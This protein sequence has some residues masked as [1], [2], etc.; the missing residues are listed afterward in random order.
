MTWTVGLGDADRDAHSRFGLPEGVAFAILDSPT[1]ADADRL[2]CLAHASDAGAREV[3]AASA[4]WRGALRSVD[5]RAED[6]ERA[7]WSA[8]LAAAAERIASAEQFASRSALALAALRRSHEAVLERFVSLE[9]AFTAQE[10]RSNHPAYAQEAISGWALLGSRANLGASARALLPFDVTGLYALELSIDATEARGDVLVS[11]ESRQSE[12]PVAAWL[13]PVDGEPARWVRFW[14]PFGL[15][16]PA[17]T[18]DL[19]IAFKGEGLLRVGLGPLHPFDGAALTGES[20]RKVPRLM[21][22]RSFFTVSGVQ[23]PRTDEDGGGVRVQLEGLEDGL[24]LPPPRQGVA[25]TTIDARVPAGAVSISAIAMVDHPD[26]PAVDFA[27]ALAETDGDEAPS[28]GWRTGSPLHP[29]S[30]SLVLPKPAVGGQGLVF[31]TRLSPTA[32]HDENAKAIFRSLHAFV[33]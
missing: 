28:S 23:A 29:T 21:A 18:C 27:L 24:L 17:A 11:I 7:L 10:R 16:E 4:A 6:A 31:K 32:S 2:L 26:G 1:I 8:C 20:D 9:A 22:L 13:E 30:V 25:S 12:R 3:A 19:R 5:L 14:R 15:C 33:P